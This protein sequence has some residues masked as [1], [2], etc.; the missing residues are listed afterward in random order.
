LPDCLRTILRCW[1]LRLAALLCLTLVI[2]VGH[3][4]EAANATIAETTANATVKAKKAAKFGIL[5][6][7][8]KAEGMA[9]WQPLFDYLNISHPGLALSFEILTYPELEAAI[10][11]QRV[12]FVLTQPA[13]YLLLAQRENLQ[14]P[15]A[16]LV[17]QE[18]GKPLSGFGGVIV[19]RPELKI[20]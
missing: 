15:I 14:S 10:R 20:R 1:P 13:H 4:E 5:A 9:R 16:T 3:A 19:T 11:H 2:S 17:E 6:V 7:R 18:N 8:P 12:D